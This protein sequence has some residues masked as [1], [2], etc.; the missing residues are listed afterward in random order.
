MLKGNKKNGEHFQ[1]YL[2][3]C[4]HVQNIETIFEQV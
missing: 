2:M 3:C 4:T 1:Q